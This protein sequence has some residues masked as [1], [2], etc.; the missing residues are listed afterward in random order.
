MMRPISLICMLLAIGS[1]LYLYRVKYR[2][3]MLD[4]EIN[5]TLKSADDLRARAALLRAD[6]ALL[7]DPIRL[8]ELVDQH[9]SLKTTQPT[10][11]TTLAD[12]ERRLPPVG[13]AP[14]EPQPEPD[15]PAAIIRP[16]PRGPNEPRLA[17]PS[18]PAAILAAIPQRPAPPPAAQA[19]PAPPIAAA[20]APSA[21]TGMPRATPVP[22][23]GTPWPTTAAPPPSS[24]VA[25][26]APTPLA[27]PMPATQPAAG[28]TLPITQ[29]AARS[30]PVMQ[31]PLP[32]VAA[33]P[34]PRAF[35]AQPVATSPGASSAAADQALP[36]VRSALGMA[37][38]PPTQPSQTAPGGGGNN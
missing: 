2:A 12:F 8:Q 7:N 22:A 26:R 36:V 14:P 18:R 23:P 11:F 32:P 25:P 27:L 28:P 1:G 29:M 6:Y 37:R 30:P 20:P 38:R 3:Q 24:A 31:A 16:G 35:P 5:L 34:A 17:E 15:I 19:V 4:R 21:V 33:P 13:I 9:L 10:Q